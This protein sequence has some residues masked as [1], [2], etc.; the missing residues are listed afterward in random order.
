MRANK[1][2]QE[3]RASVEKF[4]AT[5]RAKYGNKYSEHFREIGRK[6]GSVIRNKPRGFGRDLAK[7]AEW[8]KIGGRISR[9]NKKFLGESNGVRKYLDKQTGKVVEYKV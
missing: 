5:M 3:G 1:N 8:G 9:Q 7:A 6:G 2:T 4:K